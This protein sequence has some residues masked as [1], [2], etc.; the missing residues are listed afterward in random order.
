MK[1]GGL[2]QIKAVKDYLV[3]IE[4]YD[5][6]EKIA[7][8]YNLPEDRLEEFLDLTDAVINEQVTIDQMPGLIAKAFGLDS[9]K[10]TQL[11]ADLA[12][13]RLLPLENFIPNVAEQIVSWG[14]K[15]ENFPKFRV[16]K[17]KV[18]VDSHLRNLAKEIGLELPEHIMK[19]FVY[20]SKNYLLGKQD[21]AATLK[22]LKRRLNIGGLELSDDQAE[23][24]IKL[25]NAE[26]DE[27]VPKKKEVS[28]PRKAVEEVEA[29][30]PSGPS[31][32]PGSQRW[33]TCATIG[34]QHQYA[35]N[36][37]RYKTLRTFSQRC[38]DPRETNRD[39][40]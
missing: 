34:P 4:I 32:S 19:R 18:E 16:E 40:V 37:S 30:A 29:V 7:A 10:S 24:L 15:V 1:S 6:L 8:K 23:N 26:K 22:L 14:G 5:H 12:G 25:L 38:T 21:K 35:R 11:A 31:T 28:K 20:L 3:K 2:L 9:Q 17:A 39:V 36:N 33:V 27:V 13:Y